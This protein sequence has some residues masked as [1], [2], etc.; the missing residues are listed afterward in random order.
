M[1]MVRVSLFWCCSVI[2]VQEA[3]EETPG[4]QSSFP[5]PIP[6]PTVEEADNGEKEDDGATLFPTTRWIRNKVFDACVVLESLLFFF[7]A[8]CRSAHM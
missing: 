7:F 4:G 1:W 3:N 6:A 5:A 2:V 8:L